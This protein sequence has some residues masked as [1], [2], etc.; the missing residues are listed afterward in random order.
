MLTIRM[1]RG[2]R[3]GHPHYRIVAQDSRF[4]PTSGRVVAQLGSYDP[5]TKAVTID[6]VKVATLIQNG[7]QPSPRVVTV[8]QAL[9]IALPTWVKAR[10]SKT[11]SIRNSGK[12]R[13]NIPVQAAEEV[14]VV[15]EAVETVAAEEVVAEA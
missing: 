8:L 11:S 7:A 6:A 5:H 15:D 10:V 12:L 14:P 1:Q 13:R 9:G 2:G 4:S 3:K